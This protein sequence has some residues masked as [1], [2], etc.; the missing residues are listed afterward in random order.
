MI[1]RSLSERCAKEV[2]AIVSGSIDTLWQHATEAKALR[3]GRS[4]NENVSR[5]AR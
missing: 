4:A 5:P 1:D 3:A 2:M